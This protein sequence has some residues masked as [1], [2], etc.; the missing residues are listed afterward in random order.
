MLSPLSNA[1]RHLLRHAAVS[2]KIRLE[3]TEPTLAIDAL[4]KGVPFRGFTVMRI[5]G[6]YHVKMAGLAASF[7]EVSSGECPRNRH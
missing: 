1:F 4:I 5:S 2:R 3:F 7:F 6:L